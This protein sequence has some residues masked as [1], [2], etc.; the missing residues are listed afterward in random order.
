LK[1]MTIQEILSSAQNLTFLGLDMGKISIC[2]D[3]LVTHLFKEIWRFAG[4]KK[5]AIFG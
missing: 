3:I 2:S 4:Q 5:R 1:T